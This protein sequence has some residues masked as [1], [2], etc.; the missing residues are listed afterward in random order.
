MVHLPKTNE[1]KTKIKDADNQPY[2]ETSEALFLQPNFEILDCL[3]CHKHRMELEKV[4]H[5]C[6]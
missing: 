4:Q 5:G 2:D 6:C 1:I 3:Q